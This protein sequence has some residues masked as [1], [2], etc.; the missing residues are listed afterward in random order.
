MNF[1][2]KDKKFLI[3]AIIILIVV[4]FFIYKK[5]A[6]EEPKQVYEALVVVREKKSSSA[7]KS[8]AL[9]YGDIMLARVDGKKWSKTELTSYLKIKMNLTK[10]QFD[11]LT[12]AMQEP[13]SEEE[14]DKR[15]ENFKKGMGEKVDKEELERYKE[16]LKN[17]SKTILARAYRVEMEKYFED[18]NPTQ[19]LKGQPYED[20]VFTWKIIE[21]KEK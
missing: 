14:M 1:D 19:L 3:P 10:S 16:N 20:E 8:S 11:K 17:E 7:D 4:C 12:Q 5:I 9:K 21:K 18:F 15:L 6:K 2:F 13:L